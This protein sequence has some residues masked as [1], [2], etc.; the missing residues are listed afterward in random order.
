MAG[1]TN[2]G[3]MFVGRIKDLAESSEYSVRTSAFLTPAE[4]AAAYDVLCGVGAA[5]R[6]FFWGGV[7]EA[8][9]RILVMLPDWLAPF[10]S[11][12]GAFDPA[13][14]EA[15]SD[16]I[17]SG[18]DGGEVSGAVRPVEI[19]ASGYEEPIGHRDYLGSLLALGLERDVVGDIAVTG[20]YGA[21]VFVLSGSE[22]FI[23][24]N[25]KK[26]GKSSVS[27]KHAVLDTKF[28]VPREFEI[29]SDT[30]MSLRL[31]GVVRAL[32]KISRSEAAELVEKGDVSLNY[33]P[34]TKTD[35]EIKKGDILS[36]RGYGKFIY[37][38]DRGVNRRGRIRFDARKYI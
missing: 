7:A 8:E 23:L 4:Q 13:R 6:C 18:A 3:N 24:Q 22:S 2:D 33:T 20:D 25:L 21:F 1:K 35:R 31:D 9:R 29:I 14:E 10:E 12:G 28:R 38:G 34:V 11:F 30:V 37:D 32:C 26:V 19:S 27:T 17:V 5:R 36:V 15:L 16:I